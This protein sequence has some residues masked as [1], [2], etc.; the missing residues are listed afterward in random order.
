MHIVE[1]WGNP[2]RPYEEWQFPFRPYSVPY[3]AWGPPFGG[4]GNG[5]GVYPYGGFPGPYPYSG[6]GPSFG[7]GFG[8]GGVPAPARSISQRTRPAVARWALS[9]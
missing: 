8:P 4:L 6:A 5:V 9:K 3:D 1:Q 2:V 7:P